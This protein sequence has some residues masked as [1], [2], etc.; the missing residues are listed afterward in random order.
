M[1]AFLQVDRYVEQIKLNFKWRG[2]VFKMPAVRHVEQMKINFI[3]RVYVFD[4]Y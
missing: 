2:F 1:A 3:W 4:F